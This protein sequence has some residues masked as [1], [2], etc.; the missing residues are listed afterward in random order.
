M[1]EKNLT[2]RLEA[3]IPDSEE[4]ATLAKIAQEEQLEAFRTIWATK[5][6]IS[7]FG[8]FNCVVLS[9]AE[10]SPAFEVFNE[11]MWGDDQECNVE[12]ALSATELA[13]SARLSENSRRSIIFT[14]AFL[15][16]TASSVGVGG[17]RRAVKS[18]T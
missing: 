2:E 6:S 17:D 9:E 3:G 11:L 10:I 16:K 1:Q 18:C 14:S 4:V 7:L 8:D 15:R 5:E 13:E 12:I